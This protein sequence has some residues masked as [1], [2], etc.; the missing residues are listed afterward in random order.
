MVPDSPTELTELT[1]S[2]WKNEAFYWNKY[3]ELFMKLKIGSLSE[4]V[5]SGLNPMAI[6]AHLARDKDLLKKAM[7]KWKQL[8][9]E[10]K[11]DYLKR[12]YHSVET[13]F[14]QWS[15]EFTSGNP[16]EKKEIEF[17]FSRM[18]NPIITDVDVD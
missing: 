4:K 17:V 9:E 7:N 5:L 16:P 15:N 8:V 11:I 13:G 3:V 6:A 18:A 14:S 12:V 10:T 2:D 1:N